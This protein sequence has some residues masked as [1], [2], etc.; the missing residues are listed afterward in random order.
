MQLQH[1]FESMT[2]C[3]KHIWDP[4]E[5]CWGHCCSMPP[6]SPCSYCYLRPDAHQDHC[7]Q[8]LAFLFQKTTGSESSLGKRKLNLCFINPRRACAARVT[9]VVLRESWGAF[10]SMKGGGG[11]GGEG[12][13]R[14]GKG[15]RVKVQIK[16]GNSNF[17]FIQK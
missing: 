13:E 4:T 3:R 11:G 2:M 12:G 8:E 9:V 5:K 6:P 10:F 14:G 15:K 7:T 1:E 16:E 17:I